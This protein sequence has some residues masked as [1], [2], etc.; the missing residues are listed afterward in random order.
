[1]TNNLL[2]QINNYTLSGVVK[3]SESGE[4]LI[5]A[6]VYINGGTF[7]T[8]TNEYGFYSLSIPK[9]KDSCLLTISFIGYK[10]FVDS[11]QLQQDLTRNVELLEVVQMKEIVVTTGSNMDRINE[12]QMGVEEITTKEGKKIVALFGEV[13][14]I[15]LLALKNVRSEDSLKDK[16]EAYIDAAFD[17]AIE[18]AGNANV[19][20]DAL[21]GRK[22]ESIDAQSIKDKAFEDYKSGLENAWKKKGNK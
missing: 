15:K 9:Q 13:D 10:T 17:I 22:V 18:N 11:I 6:S 20:A 7:G 8:L 4:T 12:T 14:L 21:S 16:S 2:G 19:V 5:G 3:D 1:M